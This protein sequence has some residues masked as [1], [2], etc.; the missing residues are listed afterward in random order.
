MTE[1]IKFHQLQTDSPLL[2]HF[3]ASSL[4]DKPGATLPRNWLE[5]IALRIGKWKVMKKNMYQ[6]KTAAPEL[7]DLETDPGEKSNVA[8]EHPDIIK[9]AEGILATCSEANTPWFPYKSSD[10]SHHEK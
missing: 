10:I 3:T 1:D 9:K 5:S 8:A 7:Y 6:D 4:W 2:P